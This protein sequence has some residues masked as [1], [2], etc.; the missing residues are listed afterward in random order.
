MKIIILL[1]SL[2]EI[3][4][5]DTVLICSCI[6]N[7]RFIGVLDEKLF[8]TY[9]NCKVISVGR[10]FYNRYNEEIWIQP[11]KR[12]QC[13]LCKNCSWT[14]CWENPS[15]PENIRKITTRKENIHM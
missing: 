1:K 10:N 9:K 11:T 14:N 8:D 3:I 7:G 5:E 2:K 6:A 12:L 15:H 4:P 13:N